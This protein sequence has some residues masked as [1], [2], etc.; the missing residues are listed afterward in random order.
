MRALPEW[1]RWTAGLRAG[2]NAALDL[3]LPPRCLACQAV[4]D[5]QGV[6]CPPCWSGLQFIG[7]PYCDSCGLPF[8]FDPGGLSLCGACL[9]QLPPFRRAR[10]ALAYGE[11]SRSL[12]LGFKHADRTYA[13][14]LLGRWL[15]R[16][17]ADLLADAALVVPVPLHRWRLFGRR[18]NQAALLAQALGRIG[19]VPVAV[20][21]LVRRRATPNQA[22]RSRSGRRRNVE[23]AFCLRP[24]YGGMVDGQCVLL[25][26]D[27]L[28][29]GATVMECTKVLK[30]SGAGAVDVVTLARVLRP[31][32]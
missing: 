23:G 10:A 9:R 4:V 3:L 27:V 1:D 29:T 18:Y 28:T 11:A 25:V 32:A 6:L 17:A 19:E 15:G 13:A 12:V 24:G 31:L 21:L 20:D 7:P 30:R 26:D 16:V 2:A 14:P 5:R 8:D 22:G